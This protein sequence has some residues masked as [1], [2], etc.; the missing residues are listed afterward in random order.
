MFVSLLIKCM[1]AFGVVVNE[2][3]LLRRTLH[4]GKIGICHH[5]LGH[6][7]FVEVVGI[8]EERCIWSWLASLNKMY[9]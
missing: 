8:T 9:L 5:A 4:C 6:W 7:I 3:L 2:T 1:M